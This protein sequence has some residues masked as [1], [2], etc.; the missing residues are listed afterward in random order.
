MEIANE[1]QLSPAH[2]RPQR[3]NNVNYF[4]GL[5]GFLTKTDDILNTLLRE[6][7]QN[8]CLYTMLVRYVLNLVRP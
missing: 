4:V 7:S 6:L 1:S 2:R 5:E 3:N 8:H